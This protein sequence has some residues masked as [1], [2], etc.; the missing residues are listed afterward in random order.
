MTFDL[1]IQ[2][3]A[4]EEIE[5]AARWYES[6]EPGL[7]DEFL[8]HVHATLRRILEDPKQFPIVRRGARRAIVAR[9]PYLIFYV[10]KSDRV[11]VLSCFHAKRNPLIWQ[12]RI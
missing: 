7:G 2:P 12:S 1:V 11:L 3:P 5:D 6:E 8:V 10:L 9:F 4:G